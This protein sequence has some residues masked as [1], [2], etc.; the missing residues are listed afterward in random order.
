M[1][2]LYA[3]CIISKNYY[4]HIF[5]L[6]IEKPSIQGIKYNRLLAEGLAH[7]NLNKVTTIT[8][9][10]MSRK[11][12]KKNIWNYKK[13]Y[14]NNIKYNYM[15]FINFPLFRHIILFLSSF[16]YTLFYLESNKNTIIIG[17][18]LSVSV[19][20]GSLI[21]S[22]LRGFKSIA[23]ITDLPKYQNINRESKSKLRQIIL[24]FIKKTRNYFINQYDGYVLMTEEMNNEINSNLKPS[25]I[26]EGIAD[27]EMQK[28]VND[29][30]NKCK[31][32]IILYAG[33]LNEKYGL[34]KLASAFINI[35]DSDV[36]LWIYG[37]GELEN[38]IIEYAKIDSRIKYF[39][40]V[41]NEEVINAELKSTILINPR[42][43]IEEF[44][45][46]SFPS[47]NIEYMSSGTPLLTTPLHGMPKE[48]FKYVYIFNDESELGIKNRLLEILS[49]PTDELHQKGLSAKKFILENKNNIA[50]AKKINSLAIKI[51]SN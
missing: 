11:I 4:N 6:S 36:E 19:S 9:V 17:D 7:D 49:Y 42:P 22:K 26:I 32:K 2:Y 27:I 44:T 31:K 47:K 12:S 21:A 33:S 3:S 23:I 51:L 25:I 38:I 45:R 37:K 43:T 13:D 24:D 28:E 30:K 40:M 29:I 41:S 18:V 20:A 39:G 48:Y 46:F 14:E 1:N 5:H 35:K 15:P 34:Q 50:Q 8:A 10:Q 16:F